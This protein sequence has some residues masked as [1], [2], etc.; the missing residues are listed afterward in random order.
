MARTQSP[1]DFFPNHEGDQ[2]HHQVQS[3]KFKS[4][5]KNDKKILEQMMNELDPDTKTELQSH[6]VIKL[7]FRRNMSLYFS[8]NCCC[9]CRPFQNRKLMRLYDKSEEKIAKSLDIVKLVKIIQLCKTLV[10]TKFIGL[11]EKF[12]IEHNQKN[13][14]NLEST[15]ESEC[16][17]G[18]SHSVSLDDEIRA[19]ECETLNH[20]EKKETLPFKLTAKNN[21]Y[22]Q[23]IE[24]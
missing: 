3:L 12:Q 14:I 11:R 23:I 16:C 10:K 15:S 17:S 13:L 5:H 8:K 20:E 19:N 6:H 24:K 1:Q 2:V 18:Q 4:N 22:D 21:C 7:D 9:F